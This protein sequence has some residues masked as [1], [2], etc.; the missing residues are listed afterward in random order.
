MQQ[1]LQQKKKK[2][3]LGLGFCT[4]DDEAIAGALDGLELS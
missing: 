1:I 4:G 3:L 2:V